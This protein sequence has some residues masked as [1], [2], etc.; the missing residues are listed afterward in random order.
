[1]AAYLRLH[2]E[3]EVRLGN[4]P[5]PIPKRIKLQT[6][7]GNPYEQKLRDTN[8]RQWLVLFAMTFLVGFNYLVLEP[9]SNRGWTI[10]LVVAV[11]LVVVTIY[12]MVV[13][14]E[15]WLSAE[16]AGTKDTNSI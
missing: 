14:R 4:K 6:I 9:A 16:R 7:D 2:H 10:S 12:Y 5:L 3:N 8:F 13:M 11:I 15:L 1:M